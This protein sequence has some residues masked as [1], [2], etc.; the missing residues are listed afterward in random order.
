M[1][2]VGNEEEEEEESCVGPHPIGSPSSELLAHAAPVGSRGG[3]KE[4]RE[5]DDPISQR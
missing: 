2:I 3:K 1:N 5:T 4:K